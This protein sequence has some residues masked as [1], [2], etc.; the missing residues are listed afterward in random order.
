MKEYRGFII[1]GALGFVCVIATLGFRFLQPSQES[2]TNPVAAN[3][4]HVDAIILDE[5]SISKIVEAGSIIEVIEQ[6]TTDT[7]NCNN[8]EATEVE[9]QRTR[10]LEHSV[11]IE[12]QNGVEIGNTQIPVLSLL[13]VTLEEKY[14]I[15]DKEIEQ[16]SYNIKFRT[17]ANKWATHTVSWK[18]TWYTGNAILKLSNGEEQVY[19]YKIR[20]LL[21]PEIKS[22]EKDCPLFPTTSP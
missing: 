18:Y 14:G 9:T 19:N 1:I 7:N 5:A 21:Q 2:K 20:A 15:Q 13:K 22:I 3:E 6:E 17:G 11:V 12:N 4:T 10:I 8:S 16:R